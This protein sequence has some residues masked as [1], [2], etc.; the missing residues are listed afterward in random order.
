M[1]N[2]DRATIGVVCHDRCVLSECDTDSNT[3]M[4]SDRMYARLDVDRRFDVPSHFQV[5]LCNNDAGD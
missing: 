4:K 3:R 5:E 1:A 2:R